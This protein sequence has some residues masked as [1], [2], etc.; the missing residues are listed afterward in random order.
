M[1]EVEIIL[2]SVNMA[3]NDRITTI[4]CTLCNRILSVS[5]F[6]KHGGTKDGYRH[7]CKKCRRKEN[8]EWRQKSGAKPRLEQSDEW[9]AQGKRKCTHCLEI[10]DLSCFQHGHGWCVDC[11]RSLNEEWRRSKGEQ[12]K[13]IR[14]PQFLSQGLRECFKCDR[15][16]SLADFY[17]AQSHP[18]GYSANCKDCTKKH[19]AKPE[20]RKKNTEKVRRLRKENPRYAEIHRKQQSKRRAW[21][22]NLDS[23]LVTQEFLDKLYT[24][25]TCAYCKEFVEP[26]NRTMDHVIPLKRGGLHHPDNLIMAC[27]SCNFRKSS[28]T[29]DEF[30]EKLRKTK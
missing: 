18:D 1:I 10:K 5:E 3:T 9:I 4:K 11:R 2:D 23:G 20:I 14:N 27:G 7:Q 6:G 25:E 28:S 19:S 30:M 24:T 15:V 13:R 29:A 21:K 26:K 17:Q 16:L 8:R 22:N 12:K